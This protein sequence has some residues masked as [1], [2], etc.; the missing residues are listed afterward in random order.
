M[1]PFVVYFN[2]YER[3]KELRLFCRV[4]LFLTFG[5]ILFSFCRGGYLAILV[6]SI[7]LIALNIRHRFA[8]VSLYS[9]G[10]L[11]L[12][13]DEVVE[14]FLTIIPG[15]KVGGN[16]VGNVSGGG[17]MNTTA[18]IINNSTADLATNERFKIWIEAWNSFIEQPIFGHG[19][20][21]ETT[22]GILKEAGLGSIHAHNIVLQ[23]LMEGGII[24]LIIML[25]IGAKVIK[26]GIELMRNNYGYAYWIG[27]GVLGFAACFIIQ[28][29]VDYPLMTPK[30]VC[31]FMTMIAIVERSNILYPGKGIEVRSRIRRRMKA[32]HATVIAHRK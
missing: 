20:G 3:R 30:L 26:N 14:R 21:V 5:G 32:A 13:P 1:A 19:A 11:L 8:S 29:V 12:L 25:F 24:A 6:L 2:F 9:I 28:G 15:V 10:A 16:I 27:F 4:C 31:N 7:G 22:H 17:S 18:D 23:L